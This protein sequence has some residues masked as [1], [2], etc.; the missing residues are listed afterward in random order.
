MSRKIRQSN[1]I[2]PSGVGALIDLQ[3]ESFVA[4]DIHRWGARGLTLRSERLAAVLGVANFRSAPAVTSELSGGSIAGVPYS[5]FP[6]W[7]FCQRCR[8]MVRWK[9]SWE[10]VSTSPKCSTCAGAM[11]LVPMRW[12]QIC[13]NGHMDDIDWRRWA[14]S[15]NANPEARQCQKDQ[16]F[17]RAIQGKGSGGLA[18]LE[19]HCGTCGSRRNLMGIT[20][21]GSLKSIGSGCGGRQ[22]WQSNN[23]RVS[24]EEMPISVERGAS[25]TYFPLVHSSIEIP[26]TSGQASTDHKSD[27]IREDVYFRVL[28]SMNENAPHFNDTLAQVARDHSVSTNYVLAM[29]RVDGLIDASATAATQRGPAML[30]DDEWSALT[31]QSER[32]DS[33]HFKSRTVRLSSV[34]DETS[35]TSLLVE[36]V[37][38]VVLVDHLREVRVLEGFHR[39]T[40]GGK[41]RL[42]KAGLNHDVDWLPGIEVRGEGIFFSLDEYR[43][44]TWEAEPEVC[45][46][47]AR[48]D[49]RLKASFM[50]SRLRERIGPE[51]S[52]R[53]V[54]LHTFAHLLMRRLAYESGYAATSLRE[55]IYA[56]RAA[57]PNNGLNHAGVLIYTAANDSEGTLGGLV[58]QGEMPAFETTIVE[59]LQDAMWCSSDPLCSENT[60]A[61]FDGLN[62]SACHACSLVAETSCENG[63]YLLDRVLVVGNSRVAGFFT[64]VLTAAIS[65]ATKE[66]GISR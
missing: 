4:C 35:V 19:I 46:R 61:G 63:N 14:H 50:D 64:P 15:R 30:L 40:P 10:K 54:L 27:E 25:N 5:R 38:N 62:S 12:I 17:F 52:P 2:L 58:R 3:G 6:T 57:R 24:C 20:A 66:I 33:P 51:L 48:L 28:A 26:S 42:V 60:S 44:A 11:P 34:D 13:V 7:L 39:V 59:A 37:N 18:M 21:K 29:L 31:S 1:T 23:D 8:G 49:A 47:V 43:L 53:Y 22:P 16:L 9:R 41:E 45:A 32:T 56:L 36:R 55:R 65:A